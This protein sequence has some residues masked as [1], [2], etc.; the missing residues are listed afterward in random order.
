MIEMS[1]YLAI[2]IPKH[3]PCDISIDFL[4][5]AKRHFCDISL[6]E[7]ARKIEIINLLYI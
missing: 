4:N 7:Y 6:D 1:E 2:A 5:E 3:L